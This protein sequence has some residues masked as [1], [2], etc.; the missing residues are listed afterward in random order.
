LAF[1]LELPSV[2]KQSAVVTFESIKE[3]K[4]NSLKIASGFIL[5]KLYAN[6]PGKLFDQIK[7][8]LNSDDVKKTSLIIAFELIAT[9]SKNFKPPKYL[10]DFIIEC[11]NSSDKKLSY[12]ATRACLVNL[13]LHR[14]PFETAIINYLEKSDD[15]KIGTVILFGLEIHM[16]GILSY[17][18]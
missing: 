9:V 17:F 5:G 12:C 6:S 13:E 11:T 10:L 7:I 1:L 15:N 14:Q 18:Y 3:S 16:T 8:H 4:I 2:N